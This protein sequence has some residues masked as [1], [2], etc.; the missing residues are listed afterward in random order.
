MNS[1]EFKQY[2]CIPAIQPIGTMY[3]CVI[4]SLFLQKIT[5]AHTRRAVDEVRDVE[6]YV[7]IQRVLDEKRKK[8]I[9]K[10]V[11][12]SDASFPN[13][14]I[15]TI[16]SKDAEYDEAKRQISIRDEKSIASVL[17][18]QH[19]VAGLSLLEEG[20][21]FDCIVTIFIDM[22]MEDQAVIFSTINTEQKKV[23][24]SLV[25]DLYELYQTRNPQRTCHNIARLLN[26][27]PQSPFYNKISTLGAA[28]KSKGE[29]LTQYIFVK[30]LLQ[31]ISVTPLQ[32]RDFMKQK[33]F[34]GNH[35]RL[36]LKP[37]DE[38]KT[39]LRKL[40]INDEDD[41]DIAQV[42][43]NYFKAVKQKW[44]NSWD[45]PSTNNILNKTTGY[46]AL[47]KLFKDLY[48]AIGKDIP[49]VED[50]YDFLKK[51]KLDD[52]SFTRDTYQT[53]GVGQS[54][55]YKRLKEII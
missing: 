13:S 11:N 55:L 12:L 20:K 28:D 23:N 52:N 34:W 41:S 27:N 7:G 4:D 32:D 33:D 6:E 3:V 31:H 25:A 50:F 17:D 40:F 35:K 38:K 15:L 19:R 39:C 1:S 21:Q 54:D 8:E 42:I 45:V 47:M 10:Y 48:L 37:G 30:E 53:G 44:P 29:T 36:E 14:V 24:K 16:S 18:G 51:S 9:G 2:N 5:Y 43:V 26:N 22:E 49:S 46:I